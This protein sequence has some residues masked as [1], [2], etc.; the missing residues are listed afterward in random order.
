MS[1]HYTGDYGAGES[2]ICTGRKRRLSVINSPQ[3][4]QF[5]NLCDSMPLNIAQIY[6]YEPYAMQ[7]MIRC[8]S[9]VSAKFHHS[10]LYESYQ[11]ILFC[12]INTTELTRIEFSTDTIEP[13]KYFHIHCFNP[14]NIYPLIGYTRIINQNTRIPQKS[15]ISPCFF[16]FTGLWTG[17]YDQIMRWCCSNLGQGLLQF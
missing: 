1:S 12:T 6:Y 5:L 7:R 10:T 2:N 16:V 3:R 8:V 13:A 14:I 4:V 11:S 17:Q 15:K 9:G